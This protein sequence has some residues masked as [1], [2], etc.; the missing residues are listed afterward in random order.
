M[1]QSQSRPKI[2]GC[3][4]IK[5]V[6]DNDDD[7]MIVIMMKFQHTSSKPGTLSRKKKGRRRNWEVTFR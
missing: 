2:S 4:K 1:K 3:V 6:E 7:I 5:F